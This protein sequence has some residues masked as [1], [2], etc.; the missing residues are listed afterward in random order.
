[1]L[2]FDDYEWSGRRTAGVIIISI[3]TTTAA[4]ILG[5]LQRASRTEKR[6]YEQPIGSKLPDMEKSRMSRDEPVAFLTRYH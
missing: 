1:M 2:V 3:E 4:K 6:L 5:T